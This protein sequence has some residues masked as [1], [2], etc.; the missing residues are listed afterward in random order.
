[1]E[2]DLYQTVFLV[3]VLPVFVVDAAVYRTVPQ[4]TAVLLGHDVTLNCSLSGLSEQ[5]V[6]NWHWYNRASQDKFRHISAGS[7]VRNE[8]SR[9]SIVG[10]TGG[11]EFNLRIQNARLEDEGKYQCS[12][13]LCG[14]SQQGCQV[15]GC[16]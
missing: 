4:S 16:R 13:F 5:D 2:C 14:R 7:V 9:Y 3:V 12:V 1:M 11:G 15:N 10:D 6:V 8:L